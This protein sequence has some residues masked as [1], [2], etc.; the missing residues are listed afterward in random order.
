MNFEKLTEGLDALISGL[1]KNDEPETR[2][3][4]K[5]E[6]ATYAEEQVRA[7]KADTEREEENAGDVAKE[8][9]VALKAAADEVSKFE[10]KDGE[11]PRV[12]IFRDPWQNMPTMAN[13]NT[14]SSQPAGGS[15]PNHM[16][17][18]LGTVEQLIEAAIKGA[19]D[20]PPLEEKIEEAPPATP[21]VHWPSDMA[22]GFQKNE[23]GE[24]IKDEPEWGKDPAGVKTL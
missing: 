9:L 16:A 11:L 17:K 10:F 20:T 7:A 3:M 13:G 5:D 23:K 18:S 19:D 8:R 4:T 2:E 12:T 22:S 6:F 15:S 21:D 14:K 24:I 1:E